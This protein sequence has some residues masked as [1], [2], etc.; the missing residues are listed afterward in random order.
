MPER[1]L[2]QEQRVWQAICVDLGRPGG[3]GIKEQHCMEALDSV[4]EVE[5]SS[6]D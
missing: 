2:K 1:R 3:D 5:G 6:L 4:Q